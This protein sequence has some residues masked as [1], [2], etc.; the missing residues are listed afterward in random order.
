MIN[1]NINKEQDYNVEEDD[2]RIDDE[3]DIKTNIDLME[4]S[5][6]KHYPNFRVKLDSTQLEYL[7]EIPRD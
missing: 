5:I 1:N 2:K 3:L 6:F 4:D 7:Q